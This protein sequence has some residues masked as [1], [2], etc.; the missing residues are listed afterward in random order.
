[1]LRRDMGD[2][3]KKF[4]RRDTQSS[5]V[6]QVFKFKKNANSS[7]Y[8]FIFLNHY[9]AHIMVIVRHKVL[10]DFAHFPRGA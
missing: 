1:V 3:K 10:R 6:E 7:T 4:H 2:V 9:Y 5:F 8:W